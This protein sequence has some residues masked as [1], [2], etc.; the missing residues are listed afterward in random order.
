MGPIELYRT[1][2]LDF[3]SVGDGDITQPLWHHAGEARNFILGAKPSEI[4][5]FRSEP[6]DLPPGY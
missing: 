2:T 4:P 1:Q 6:S 5:E 3:F